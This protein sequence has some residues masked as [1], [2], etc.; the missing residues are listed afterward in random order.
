MS[1]LGQRAWRGMIRAYEGGLRRRPVFRYWH[2]LEES[3]WWSQERLAALQLERLQ[4]LVRHAAS[5]SPWYRAEWARLEL[6]P[7]GLQ[8]ID[9]FRRWPVLT[10]E[11]IRAHREAMRSDDGR[12]LIAKATGGSSGVPLRF[13]LCL[14][15]NERRMAAWH[16]GYG[17]AGAAP[18][19]RQWYLWGVPP[20][21]T[22]DWRKRKVRLYDR[23]YRRTTESCF[24]L[25]ERSVDRLLAS[26]HR[27]RPDAI[28]AYT[29]AIYTFARLLEARGLVPPPPTSIVVGAEK[30]H[31][32]Q[33]EVIERVFRAPVFET[34]GSREFMLIGG[35]CAHHTGLHLTM[36]HLLVEVVDAAGT[37]VP[38]GTEGDVVITDLTNFGM[39]FIRYAN[40][41][42]A[43][44]ATATCTCGRGLPMLSAVTGRRLDILVTPEGG[45]LPGEFFPHILKERPTVQRFQVIQE[46]PDAVT[47]RLVAPGWSEADTTWLRG[48]VAATSGST[49]RLEIEQVAEI[50]LTGAGKLQVVVNRLAGTAERGQRA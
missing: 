23:L 32:F 40:G 37:P 36:E 39:P 3:Q 1:A 44:M 7:D 17:W 24:A 43:V 34:Y 28:V 4:A 9:D 26:L 41:D 45:Q 31:G 10:R 21:G 22:A 18:G 13:D 25:S 11:T 5:H 20:E 8:H 2:A 49:L 46:L 42:R 12:T 38:D 16:R 50:P 27:T 30:L 29:N 47:V 48:E 15:S 6:S 14:D 33:R 19:T 35:E